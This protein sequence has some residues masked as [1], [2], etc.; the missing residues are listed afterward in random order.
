MAAPLTNRIEDYALIGDTHSAGLVSKAGSIDWLCLPRFDSSSL[1]AAVLDPVRG[2]HWLIAPSDD[3][4]SVC[5]RYI[6]DTVVLETTFDTA[7]GTVT[8]TDC[9]AFEEGSRPDAPESVYT[10]DVVVRVVSGVRGSVAMRVE[11]APRF[12]YGNIVPWFRRRR[13]VLEAVGG[14][15]AVDLHCDVELDLDRATAMGRFAI[16][17]GEDVS[18]LAAY[19]PSHEYRDVELSHEV[20]SRLIDR[21]VDFWRRW[22]ERCSY[23]GRWREQILRS[24]LTLKALTY[25]PTGGIVAA[26]TTSLP[27]KIGGVRNWD[28]R[29]CWLRDATFSLDVLLESGYTAEAVAW[30]DWLLRAVAG[31]PEDL[32]IM[33]GLH[34][35]RRLPELELEWLSGYAGSRP[36]RI[37]NAAAGQFQL[38]VYGEVMDSFH[39][40]ARAGIEPM[41]EAWALQREIVDFVCAHWDEP[42]EGIWEVRS[43]RKHFVHSKVMAWVA[44]DR[45]IKA[46]DQRGREGPRDGWIET[47]DTIKEEVLRRGYDEGRESFIRAY[48]ELELDASLLMLPLVGFIDA[49][50]PRMTSTIDAIAR[51][52]MH[53]GLVARYRTEDSDDGLPPGEGAFLLCTFWLADCYALLGRVE[54]AETIMERLVGLCNDVGLLSEQYDPIAR[55]FLGNFPQAFSHVALV[56]TAM[57][58]EAAARVP[59]GD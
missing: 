54:E 1:F 50:D 44:V 30:R 6:P 28:Y 40:A 29:Y 53:D 38:D 3:V 17:A 13:N 23:R 15:D 58:L 20:C 52:L 49:G 16:A 46:I 59:R 33:Y 42:D 34:G 7:S 37:G 51:E 39:S 31:D 5:R 11:Y 32:L 36:V 27:E 8:L 56:T 41:D 26:P 19:H 35:E 10:K 45:A 47:R 22:V 9:L 4:V 24:L 18:F 2:G 14:P 57:T 55:R 21:T 12:D 43:G 48:D 25:S